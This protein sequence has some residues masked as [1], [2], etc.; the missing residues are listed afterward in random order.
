VSVAIVIIVVHSKPFTVP[1]S[2]VARTAP[3]S[4]P[5]HDAVRA[6]ARITNSACAHV[7]LERPPTGSDSGPSPHRSLPWPS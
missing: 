4:V 1:C 2:V 3:T 6:G 5:Q 7:Q